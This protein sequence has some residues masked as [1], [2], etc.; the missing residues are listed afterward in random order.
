MNQVQLFNQDLMSRDGIK[1]LSDAIVQSLDDGNFNP[2]DFKLA[3][4]GFEKLMEAVKKPID[5]AAMTEAEKYSAKNFTYK[6]A[7]IQVSENLGVSYDYSGC[8][9]PEYV[10]V[11][12]EFNAIA[13]RKKEIEAQLQATKHSFTM[14][15]EDTGEVVTVYPPIK[16]SS[17]GIKITI[18]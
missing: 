7:D 5:K 14:I 10:R 4:K 17:S 13:K 18:K 15:D 9:H 12:E 16:S 11:L 8:N 6:G 3:A 2:L 1:K